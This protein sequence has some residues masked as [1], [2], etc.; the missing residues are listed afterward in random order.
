MKVDSERRRLY[1]DTNRPRCSGMLKLP[2]PVRCSRRSIVERGG[3]SYCGLH[4]PQRKS[5]KTRKP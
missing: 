2:F 4:D 5:S 3:R 1:R